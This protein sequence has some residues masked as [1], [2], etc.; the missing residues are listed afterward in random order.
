MFSEADKDYVIEVL[1]S[2][3]AL[4]G[5]P[6]STLVA[7]FMNT[8]FAEDLVQGKARE[9]AMDAVR[10]CIIDGWNHKPTWMERLL[11][12]YAL[13]VADAKVAEIWERSKHQPPPAADPLNQTVLNNSIPFVNRKT[14]RSHLKRLATPGANLQP[15]LVLNGSSCCGKSYSTNYISHFSNIR[16]ITAYRLSLDPQLGLSMGPREVAM[17]LVYMMGRP[18]TNMPAP[19]TNL[20]LYARQLASWVLNEAAQIPGQHWFVLDNFRGDALLPE[21][22]NFLTALSD[23]I[24]TGIF[25]QR[26]RLILIGFDR[27]VL[28][29]DPGM[30]EEEWIAHCTLSDVEATVQEI[31]ERADGQSYNLNNIMPYVYDNLP[32][33]TDKMWELNQRLR[34]LLYAVKTLSTLLAGRSDISFEPVL[35]Q[36]LKDLPPTAERIQELQKRLNNLGDTLNEI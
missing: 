23:R 6:R 21:T 8:T 15:I 22:R 4:E 30:V 29:V 7:Y 2:R 32:A 19:E 31:M 5:S 28:T 33:G 13:T 9:L 26:C 35:L 14:L 27:A 11:D 34:A 10:L 36:M 3:L 18:L 12:V 1:T 16:S 25:A 17:D 20:N 24:T